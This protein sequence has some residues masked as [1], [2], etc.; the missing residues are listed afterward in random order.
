MC[1]AI[2][3]M[4]LDGRREGEKRG[5]KEEKTKAWHCCRNYLK[6]IGWMMPGESAQMKRTVKSF[7]EEYQLS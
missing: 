4:I 3:E 5:E 1:T 7:Y 2:D 6:R